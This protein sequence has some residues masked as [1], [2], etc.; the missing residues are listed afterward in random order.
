[1]SLTKKD[2]GE[3]NIFSKYIEWY[4]TRNMQ[5]VRQLLRKHLGRL[6]RRLQNQVVILQRWLSQLFTNK[7]KQ[8]QT[9]FHNGLVAF[10]SGVNS[11]GDVVRVFPNIVQGTGEANRIGDHIRSQKLTI[12]GHFVINVIPTL[13]T[14]S[15]LPTSIP[16]NCRLMIRAF[17]CSVKR[18]QNYEDTV[19][20]VASWSANFLKNGNTAQ[21]LEGSIE[22]LY[23]PVN[24]DVITVHKEIKKYISIPMLTS[25]SSVATPA[26]WIIA[27]SADPRSSVK[28]FNVTIPCKKLLK[29]DDNFFTPQNYAPFMVVSYAHLDGTSPD[30]V[31]TAVNATFVSTIHFEDV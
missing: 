4:S 3:N 30:V 12:K 20:N 27:Q 2:L 29:Y 14:T 7:Q 18:F 22:S 21:A 25:T 26:N 11:G 24:T 17:I 23:L 15:S 8:K 9:H 28:F 5:N 19:S 13:S 1:L 31:T 16:S 10:N 6:L